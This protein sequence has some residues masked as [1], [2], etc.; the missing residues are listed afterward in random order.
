MTND[1]SAVQSSGQNCAA[2]AS[3]PSLWILAISVMNVCRE[4]QKGNVVM[5]MTSRRIPYTR[6]IGVASLLGLV[7]L[8]WAASPASPARA[9]S[10]STSAS[11]RMSFSNPSPCG[12]YIQ[13]ITTAPNRYG[14]SVQHGYV[15]RDGTANSDY[16]CNG[17]TYAAR[18]ACFNFDGST[19]YVAPM[20][21]HFFA[22][23]DQSEDWELSSTGANLRAGDWCEIQSKVAHMW[24]GSVPL[25]NDMFVVR[26]YGDGGKQAYR[27]GVRQ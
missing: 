16:W 21:Y 27:A 11:Q 24:D 18:L 13:T 3:L 2:T 6:S 4:T 17:V 19:I 10:L 14:D 5:K 9:T 22:G 15:A 23:N 7:L 20:Q 1:G 25:D 26:L 8:V 12:Q